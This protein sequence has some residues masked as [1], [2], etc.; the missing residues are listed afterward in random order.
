MSGTVG[1]YIGLNDPP[2]TA[3]S[4]IRPTFS[5]A[6]V[7]PNEIDASS[8]VVPTWSEDAEFRALQSGGR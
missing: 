1:P 5:V 2:I 6:T 7:T 3:M 4:I 8:A